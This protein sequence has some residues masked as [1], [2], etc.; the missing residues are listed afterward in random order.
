M[1]LGLEMVAELGEHATDQR[2]RFSCKA[3]GRRGGERQ[4]EKF[5][6]GCSVI[7]LVKPAREL[8]RLT[9]VP[10]GLLFDQKPAA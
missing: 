1:P 3:D 4:E 5:V 7:E 6:F 9:E 10:E 2:R 8:V